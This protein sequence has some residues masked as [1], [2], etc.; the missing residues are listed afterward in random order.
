MKSFR[1]IPILGR[2]TDV[3]PDDSTMLKMVETTTALSHDAGGNNYSLKRNKNACTKSLGLTVKSSAA[4]AQ[5]TLCMGLF[6]LYDGTNRNYFFFDN[7]KVYKFDSGWEQDEVTVATPVLFANDS[8][9]LYSIIRVGAYIVWADRAEHE[10]HKWK[11]G[12]TNSSTLIA[13]GTHY[14]F[15]YLGSFQRRVIGLYSNQTN[16]NIDI[17]WSTDWPTTAITSLNF[18]A[19]NQLWVPNDDPITGGASLGRDKFFIFCE[20]SIQQL[21]YYPDYSTPFRA[22]TVVP[23][24]GSVNHHS[25]VMANG[26]LHFYNVDLGFCSYGGGNVV[27]PISDDILSDLRTMNSIYHPLIV[28]HHLAKNKQ[29]I[30]T[31]PLDASSSCTHIVIYNYDTG[32]WEIEDKVT[33]CFDEWNLFSTQTWTTLESAV[34]GTGLWSD[35]GASA[36]WAD[37]TT[38]GKF[39]MYAHT[40]GHAYASSSE[41]IAGV[42]LEGFREEP[43]LYFGNRRRYDEL[44]EIWFDVGESGDFSI[45]VFHRS[46]NTTGQLRDSG[47]TSI[48][49]VSCNSANES[50]IYVH[51][52][53]ARLHQIKWGGTGKFVISGITFKYTESTEI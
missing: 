48:G 49:S 18:P 6:E 25:I 14:K 1:L 37:Y 44:K 19:T 40:D 47:W 32:Q 45:D 8:A 29:I 34:G 33:R 21:V 20:N 12:D 22:Y 4:N 42:A 52:D 5:A 38:T 15:R 9:D 35:A 27:T 17:R 53:P 43:V 13:S 11:H 50:M 31:V 2:K 23:D 26:Q 51:E 30:W 16:G 3:L 41:A 7:G 39:L 28:G 46:G 10:P 24:Q 36:T